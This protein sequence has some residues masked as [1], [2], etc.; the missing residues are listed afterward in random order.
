MNNLISLEPINVNLETY[1]V[2]DSSSYS[3][4]A[5]LYQL[6][7]NEK[8]IIALFSRKRSDIQNKTPTPSCILELVGIGCAINHFT[9]Y[10]KDLKKKLNI[11]T[12]SR[13]TVAAYNKFAVEGQI[14]S[15]NK[16]SS[17]LSAVHG[18][19]FNFI[20]VK[21]DSPEIR[22]VDFLSRFK[23]SS[24]IPECTN[25]SICSVNEYI[26]GNQKAD[27][28]IAQRQLS[29]VKYE[30]DFE[31]PAIDFYTFNYFR[32]NKML[33]NEERKDFINQYSQKSDNDGF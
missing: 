31:I 19:G 7:D 13:S 23:T 16:L 29:L 14:C 5:I 1:L 10:I 26:T 6:L 17:F 25:C 21:S 15:N 20:Y 11:L 18:F 3:T 8:K 27:L 33:S 22:A 12:D 4:G 9:P 2:V 32:H 30:K 28:Q 24:K